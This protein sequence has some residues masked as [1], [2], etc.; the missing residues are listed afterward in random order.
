MSATDAL[1]E[2]FA[3]HLAAWIDGG[4]G[5]PPFA[6]W[7]TAYVTERPAGLDEDPAVW[8]LRPVTDDELASGR[9]WT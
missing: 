5:S 3:E 6:P 1:A 2:S 4:L 9:L 8:P 7:I